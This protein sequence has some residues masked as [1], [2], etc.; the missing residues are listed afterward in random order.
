M[1]M[2][3]CVVICATYECVRV[4][5]SVFGCGRQSQ[6]F[7]VEHSIGGVELESGDI[8]LKFSLSHV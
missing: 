1:Q 4:L 2:R 7:R 6:P 8:L 3:G 5:P